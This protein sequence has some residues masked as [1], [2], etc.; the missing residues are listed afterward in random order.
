M[1]RVFMPVSGKMGQAKHRLSSSTIEIADR[2]SRVVGIST[3]EKRR[4]RSSTKITVY[5]PS[6]FT[7][8]IDEFVGLARTHEIR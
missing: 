6:I 7:D 2:P 4:C 8:L 3:D 5:E 1:H